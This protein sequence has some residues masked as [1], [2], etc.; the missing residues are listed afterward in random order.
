MKKTPTEA[1]ASDGW[2]DALGRFDDDLRAGRWPRGPGAPTR[3]DTRDFADLGHR[4]RARADRAVTATC[5]AS[6]PCCRSATPRR[7]PW[8]ASSPR[9]RGCSASLVEHGEPRGQSPADLVSAPKR[10]ATAAQD[11]QGRPTSPRCS[12][13]SPPARRSLL[14]DRALFELAYAV[15]P[16]GGGARDAR[17]RA[18]CCHDHEEVRVEGKGGKTRV[19]PAGELALA[20]L[21]RLRRGAA[22]RRSAAGDGERA[23]VPLEVGPPAVDLGRPPPPAGLGHAGASPAGLRARPTPCA[24]PSQRTCWRGARICAPSRSCWATRPSRTTQIY[25]R[26]ESAR[27]RTA[28]AKSHPRA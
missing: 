13:R 9:S 28:Y 7:R 8:R 12:T 11:A 23:A 24:I 4:P 16:A 17:R 20:A 2:V 22:G 21:R 14:R 19:V 15:G 10:P 25:T 6:S 27:L 3:S 5:G 18:R 1:E 26:V